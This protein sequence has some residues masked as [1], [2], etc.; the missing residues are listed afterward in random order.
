MVQAVQSLKPAYRT[1]FTCA[2][3]KK[4]NRETAE[5][6][7]YRFRVKSRLLRLAC[8]FGEAD[9]A[10]QKRK[11]DAFGYCK[12]FLEELNGYLE[13]TLDR[14]ISELR[15]RHDAELLVVATRPRKP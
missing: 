3:S 13:K 8:S 4:V 2:T 5:A 9:K 7:S 1:V 15:A 10:V 11:G 6:L 12:R 14:R